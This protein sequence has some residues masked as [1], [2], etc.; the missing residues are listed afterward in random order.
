[1]G[2]RCSNWAGCPLHSPAPPEQPL[3]GHQCPKWL[4]PRPR[5]TGDQGSS[6][7]GLRDLCLPCSC[8]H[9]PSNTGGAAGEWPTGG[10]GA[11]EPLTG[12]TLAVKES[13]RGE[14][15]TTGI[16]RHPHGQPSPT[17]QVTTPESEPPHQ[18]LGD[19][20]D[21]NVLHS[22]KGMCLLVAVAV[23]L[24]GVVFMK[25]PGGEKGYCL[26]F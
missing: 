13:S 9:P 25:Q 11:S 10:G 24:A 4:Q 14:G 19:T 20:M 21:A 2:P 18:G 6:L 23:A 22:G 26:L 15:L 8:P 1:M 5:C 3:L 7:R 16:S 12:P 17:A